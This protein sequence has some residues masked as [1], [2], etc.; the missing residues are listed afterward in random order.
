MER[1]EMPQ[2]LMFQI[3]HFRLNLGKNEKNYEKNI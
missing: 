3:K 2:L 1:P